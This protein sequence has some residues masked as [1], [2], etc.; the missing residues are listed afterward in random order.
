[1]ELHSASPSHHVTTV[2]EL[3]YVDVQALRVGMVVQLDTGWLSHP[4]A[5]SR[6]RITSQDEIRT[7]RGLGLGHVRWSPQDSDIT[8]SCTPADT[9]PADGCA[10]A[11]ESAERLRRR[12]ALVADR[13]ALAVCERQ[14]QEASDEFGHLMA[15][16][17]GEA[18][19]AGRRAG[20]LARVLVDKM[21]PSQELCIRLLPDDDARSLATHGVHVGVL[22]LVVG[23]TL[24][25]HRHDLVDIGLGGLIHDIGKLELPDHARQWT[26]DRET[27]ALYETH[28]AKGVAMG[29]RMRVCDAALRVIAEHHELADGSGFPQRLRNDGLSVGP[30]IVALADRYDHL[31]NPLDPSRAMTPH[32]ALSQLMRLHAS[33]HDSTILGAFVGAL[34]IYPAGSLV[35]L[36]DGRYAMVVAAVKSA[37]STTS[38]VLVH[39]P[40]L[41]A[42]EALFLDLDPKAGAGIRRALRPQE[43]PPAAHEY[44]QPRRRITYGVQP[45]S[46]LGSPWTRHV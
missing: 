21:A 22:S 15:L 23:R 25:W 18:V 9:V 34:G 1:M 27:R 41:P 13:D 3:P 28:V 14:F 33:Q 10:M 44:L 32:E 29:R 6:F 26:D 45:L 19:A 35:Q 37:R 7:L 8:P 30:R 43:L 20:L 36:T 17:P 38:R 2:T 46:P 4:F 39:D 24:G 12:A 31:C 5:L 11:A 16:L 42:D 40:A